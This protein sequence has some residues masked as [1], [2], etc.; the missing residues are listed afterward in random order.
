MPEKIWKLLT[1][2]QSELTRLDGVARHMPNYELLLRPLQARESLKSSSME[3]T[4][5]TPEEL[6][7]FE[8]GPKKRIQHDQID[9][10]KEISNYGKSLRKGEELLRELPISVRLIKELHRELLDGVRGAQKD[11]GNF[12]RT[13]VYIGSDRGFIPPPPVDALNCLYKLEEYIHAENDIEPLILCF[14][15]HYQFETIHPFLDG[16]GRTGR[17]LLSLMIFKLCN[18]GRPWLYLSAFFDK[19]RDEYIN[20]LFNVSARGDWN[21]WL[22]FCLRATHHQSRDAINRFEKLVALRQEYLER[23]SSSRSV[24]IHAIVESLFNDLP[25]VSVPQLARDFNVT[26]PTAQADIKLLVEQN[27]LRRTSVS[28]RPHFYAAFDIMNVSHEDIDF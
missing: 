23:V 6:L 18:L 1:Q 11:P 14:L 22:A 3:G 16:N 19:H 8:A 10:P 2:A 28:T 4:Y 15:V 25:V 13:Q 20:G 9:T 26:Y 24:R 17:L 7:L 12:R 27:I 21:S 5:A